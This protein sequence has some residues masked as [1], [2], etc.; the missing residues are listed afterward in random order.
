[1]VIRMVHLHHTGCNDGI[2][3]SCYIPQCLFRE[4]VYADKFRVGVEM[5]S[6]LRDVPIVELEGRV[7]RACAH[8]AVE[9]ELNH[10]AVLCPIVLAVAD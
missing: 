1:M 3:C 8:A 10:L 2:M 4:L 7:A 9:C 5:L 6:Q